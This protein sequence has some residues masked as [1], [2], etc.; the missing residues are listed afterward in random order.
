MRKI[1][2]SLLLLL[3]S[4]L[5]AYAEGWSVGVGTGPFV[6]GTFVERTTRIVTDAGSGTV[7]SKLS[8]ATRPG[9]SADVQY[10][11]N[12]R[13]GFR[14]DAG[15]TRAPMKVKS[16]GSQGVS[17]DAGHAVITTFSAP[18]I[19]NLNTHGAFRV[20]LAAGP[21]YALYDMKART[22][23]GTTLSVF[24]GTRGRW[25]GVAGAGLAWWMSDRFA[26]EA[27]ADDIVT[28]SPFRRSDFTTP[29]LGGI[30]IPKTHNVHST[31]GIRYRF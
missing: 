31:V 1:L 8:A 16:S 26:L 24:D 15:W 14:V 18:F 13:L 19:V 4:T 17:F 20:H 30:K 22:G 7:T 25:G 6:F 28:G 27:E 11:F 3:A 23:G 5:P 12:D 21:S 2:P 29:T 10:D 9:G